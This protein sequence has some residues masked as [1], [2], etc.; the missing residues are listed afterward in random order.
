MVISPGAVDG[1]SSQP[2]ID[3]SST[4]GGLVRQWHLSR[5]SALPNGKE[6]RYDD[7]LG[8]SAEWRAL[9]TERNGLV[10]ISR[11]YGRPVSTA[12]PSRRM[13]EDDNHVGQETD[14]ES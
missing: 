1:L 10:N 7:M 9:P 13:V 8:E 11:V 6:V 4:D 5:F 3:P 2:A 12:L 14:E